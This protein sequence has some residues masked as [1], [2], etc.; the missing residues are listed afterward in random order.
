MFHS[1]SH[2]YVK[3][4][5]NCV[6]TVTNNALNR[7]YVVFD[8]VGTNAVST[9]NTAFSFTKIHAKMVNTL[10]SQFTIGQNDFV[11]FFGVFQ[12]N[13]QIWATWTFRIICVCMTAFRVSI[14]S[15]NRCFQRNR[16][17][18]TLIKPML[19]LNNIFPNQKAM[20]Y[21]LTKFSFFQCFENLQ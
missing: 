18:I 21:Q 1:L 8:R 17:R 20:L 4:P 15:L 14:P 9:L 2:I 10:L 7:R 19:C 13:C 16:V 5:F 6:E 3:T 11:E 12:D